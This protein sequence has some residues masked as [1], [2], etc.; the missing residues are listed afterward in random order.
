[1]ARND[2]GRTVGGHKAVDKRPHLA[3]GFAVHKSH[4]VGLSLLPQ[5]GEVFCHQRQGVIPRNFGPIVAAALAGLQTRM[6]K[7][8]RAVQHLQRRLS[9]EAA[10][11]LVERM[12]RISLNFDRPTVYYSHL[13]ATA[14]GAE[15]TGS[16]EPGFIE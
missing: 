1:V 7:P 9:F 2:V 11:S 16:F 4:G 8:L 15:G 14:S 5:V 6:L 3:P 13:Q 12:K 10:N